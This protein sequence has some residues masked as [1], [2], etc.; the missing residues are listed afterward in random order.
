M[1]RSCSSQPCVKHPLKLSC[2]CLPNRLTCRSVDE[3]L[4]SAV[5]GLSGS[6]PAYIFLMIEA[7]AD[8]GAGWPAGGS[9]DVCAEVPAASPARF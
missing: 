5:T 9:V 7:L 2:A 1:S 3:K 8:G 6:G 4:L